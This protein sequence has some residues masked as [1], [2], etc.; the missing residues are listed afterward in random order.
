MTIAMTEQQ[1]DEL[2]GRGFTVL[3]SILEAAEVTRVEAAMD[4]VA[5][6]VRK[7]RGLAPDESVT[8]RNAISRHEALLD[9]VD[10]PRILPL[11]VDAMGWNIQNRDSVLDYK[12]PQAA[13]ADPDPAVAGMAFRLRGGVRRHHPRRHHAAAGLQ[14]SAGIFRITPSPATAPYCWYPAASGGP[15]T[16]GPRGNPGSTRPTSSSSAFRP[17]APCC[18]APPCCTA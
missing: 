16:N 3:E 5:D 11:A 17:A 9:L 2:N 6:R 13:G 12:A 4:Q 1:R 10:H 18:G 15:G 8:L 14:R 7:G